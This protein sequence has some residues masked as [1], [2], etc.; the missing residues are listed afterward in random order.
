[1]L[2]IN[3][4]RRDAV[5]CGRGCN[6]TIRFVQGYSR[7][8]GIH[9]ERSLVQ[10]RKQTELDGILIGLDAEQYKVRTINKYISRK[11]INKGILS[12]IRH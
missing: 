12:T 7:M 11:Y 3:S 4:E 10:Q 5:R 9:V 1:M 8:K 6:F 2:K